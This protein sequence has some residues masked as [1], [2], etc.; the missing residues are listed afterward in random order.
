MVAASFVV[1][2]VVFAGLFQ[3]APAHRSFTQTLVH[4]VR[5]RTSCTSDVGLLVDPL[6][7]TMARSS[8]ASAP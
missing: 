7:M 6:S 4:L 8:P 3:L 2:V 1:T 5:R